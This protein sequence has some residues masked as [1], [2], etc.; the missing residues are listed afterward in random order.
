MAENM[1]ACVPHVLL[2][3]KQLIDEGASKPLDKALQWEEQQAIASARQAS[4][5]A[6]AERRESVLARGRSEKHER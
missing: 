4:A 2:Q 3:Y 1:C 6:V 5:A